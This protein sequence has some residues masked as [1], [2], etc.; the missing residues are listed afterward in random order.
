L[1]R[2]FFAAKKNK[3][4]H[5]LFYRTFSNR[6]SGK[7][8]ELGLLSTGIQPTPAWGVIKSRLG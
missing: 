4:L 1:E 6:L 8:F 3:K 7:N 5:R 2:K